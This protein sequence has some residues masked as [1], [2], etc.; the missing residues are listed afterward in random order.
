MNYLYFIDVQTDRITGPRAMPRA[1]E[2]AERIIKCAY[3]VKG[4]PDLHTCAT[5]LLGEDSE[6]FSCLGS[7]VRSRPLRQ[8]PFAIRS[9]TY[10][11][12]EE[13]YAPKNVFLCGLGTASAVLPIALLVK[14]VH[15]D[16]NVTI[17]DDLCCDQTEDDLAAALRVARLCGISVQSSKDALSLAEGGAPDAR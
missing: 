9:L 12:G 11:M 14:T 8:S 6:M 4:L 13:G 10:K 2:I 5:R 1:R 7:L 3:Q 15:P 16:A 17:L